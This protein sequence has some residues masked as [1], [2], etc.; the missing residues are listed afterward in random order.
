MREADVGTLAVLPACV[1]DDYI[2]PKHLRASLS[3]RARIEVLAMAWAFERFSAVVGQ[4]AHLAGEFDVL[5]KRPS[6][7]W[8]GYK[9][10]D[11]YAYVFILHRNKNKRVLWKVD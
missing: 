4:I 11:N 7:Y 1:L 10:A 5:R 9:N 2:V 6:N 3:R 8:S